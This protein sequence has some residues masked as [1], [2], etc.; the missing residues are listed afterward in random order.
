MSMFF[1]KV[2]GIILF[3][4]NKLGF[5]VVFCGSFLLLPFSMNLANFFIS[6][7]L[8]SVLSNFKNYFFPQIQLYFDRTTPIPNNQFGF[9][10]TYSTIQQYNRIVDKISSTL[11]KKQYRSSIILYVSHAFDKVSDDALL[12]NSKSALPR[13]LFLVK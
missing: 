13:G 3:D 5:H 12:F 6:S 7:S 1:T 11:V 2:D 8:L 9:R 4:R 10:P